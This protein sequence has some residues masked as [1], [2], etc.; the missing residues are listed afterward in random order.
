ME[1]INPAIKPRVIKRIWVWR[2]TLNVALQKFADGV[3]PFPI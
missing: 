2:S 3:H 1:S